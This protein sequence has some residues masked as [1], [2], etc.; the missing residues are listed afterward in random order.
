LLVDDT[1]PATRPFAAVGLDVESGAG[2][3]NE[4]RQRYGLLLLVL[5]VTLAFEGIAA[6]GDLQRAIGAV[7]VGADLLLAF[8]A[9]DMPARRFRIAAT[10]VAAI[11]AGLVLAALNGNTHTVVGLAA[12]ANALMIALAP[13]AVVLGIY[14]NLRETRTVTLAVVAGVLCLYLLVGL[15][16]ASAY[17]AVQNL[18]GA[19][20]FANGA[21]ALSTRAVYFSFIT[22]ATVGYG[23]FTARTNFGHTLAVSEALVGQ[24]YLVTIVASIISRLAPRDRQAA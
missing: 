9:A 16:F 6:P 18:G 5:T 24:I 13:P 7:L 3:V 15:L 12:I 20:F 19:P 23:D 8:F 21:A 11:V 2:I 17:V 1:N 10:L 22:L 4:T 14:R